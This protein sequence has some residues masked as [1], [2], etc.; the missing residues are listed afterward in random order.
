MRALGLAGSEELARRVGE[1]LSVEL[2]ACGIRWDFA[3]VMD[4]DTNPDNPVIGDRS[5]GPDVEGVGVLGAALIRGLQDGGVA[6][7]AKHFPGHGDT[8]LDSHLALPVVTHSRGRLEEVELPPFRAAIAAGVASVMTGHLLYPE[9]DEERPV[10]LS[11][12]A[13]GKLLRDELGYSGLVVSDDLEMKAVSARWTP[14]ERA[15]L[16]AEAGCDVLA[17]CSS[18]EDQVAGIEAI[19]RGLESG[20]LS[21][22]E[23]ETSVSRVR[24]VKERYVVSHPD[25]DPGLARAAAG[26]ELRASLAEEIASRSGVALA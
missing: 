18:P 11:P 5:F 8:A 20:R 4:V 24:A 1:A 7:C 26:G 17:S 22:K 3:P 16:A 6:A 21:W 2:G 12:T 13:L 9:L 14:G 10:T 23:S 25:P 19:V 15:L